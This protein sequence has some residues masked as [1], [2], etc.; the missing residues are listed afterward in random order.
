L[1]RAAS[2]LPGVQTVTLASNVPLA[3][4]APRL[5][6][7]TGEGSE[8]ITAAMAVVGPDFFKTLGIPIVGGGREFESRDDG[9]S[10]P[11]LV[12]NRALAEKLESFAALSAD[13]ILRVGQKETRYQ[14][15]G[16]VS[17]FRYINSWQEPEPMLFLPMPQ[18]PPQR[19]VLLLRTGSQDDALR[20]V[21]GG[22]AELGDHAVFLDSMTFSNH[23]KSHLAG[24]SS[25]GSILGALGSFSVLISMIGIFGALS[26]WV[27]SRERDI[28]VRFAIGADQSRIIR[29]VV[30]QGLSL[31]LVGIAL[32][33]ILSFWLARF[34]G[35]RVEGLAHLAWFDLAGVGVALL[36]I[37][38][39]ACAV[40]ALR[41][42]TQDH[43]RLLK[44]E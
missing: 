39:T 18:R 34:L 23:L 13:R 35:N 29:Q 21:R 30:S 32:G 44:R 7:Q 9:A 25:N 40:P 15:V 33:L 19:V 24:F 42:V 43:E 2:E 37:A 1:Q 17:D 14:I 12:I 8:V 4:W 31:V 20:L 38:L 26:Y 3:S 27:K 6:I 28:A 11:P 10:V 22:V 41:A 36:F 16:A 5:P